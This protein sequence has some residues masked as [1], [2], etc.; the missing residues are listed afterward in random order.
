[1]SFFKDNPIRNKKYRDWVEELPCSVCQVEPAGDHHHI[2]GV[3]DGKMGGKACDL[4]VMPLCRGHHTEMHSNGT[5]WPN[6][7]EH[8]AKTMQ[9][10]IKEGFKF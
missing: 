3:G 8:V 5:L 7:W 10:A 1:M 4:L 9:K 6:Q 2:I